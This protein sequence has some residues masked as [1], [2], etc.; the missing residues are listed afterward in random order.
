VALPLRLAAFWA[1]YRHLEH[2]VMQQPPERV[3]RASDLR[4]R[5]LGLPGAWLITGRPHPDAEISEDA[6]TLADGTTLPLRIYRPR[7][8][9]GELPVVVNFHGGGFV[10]G[11]ARQSEW[12]AS[13]VAARAGVV[14]ISVEYRLAPEHPF[15]GPGEDCYAATVWVAEHA[16]RLGVDAG[17]LAV[18]GDSAGGNLAAVVSLMARDRGGPQIGLQ[19]LIYPAADFVGEYASK[20]ENRTGPL[21]TDGDVENVVRLYFRDSNAERGD[22]YASPLR[23]EHSDLPPALVQTAHHDPIRDE[24]RAY[25]DALRRAGVQVRYTEYVDAAHGYIS[26]PN[27]VPS[28]RQALAETVTTI[29]ETFGR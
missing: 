1:V 3:R 29:R 11:N 24:G 16:E 7:G 5:A 4:N 12:W 18:M 20:R 9:G 23:A 26:V 17:R 27:L 22:P 19:V 28:A 2:P 25:A 6:A 13:S 8:V 21:L 10:S 15:P 14:V